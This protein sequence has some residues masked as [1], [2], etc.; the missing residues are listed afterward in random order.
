EIRL[1]GDRDDGKLRTH[2]VQA[3]ADLFGCL[4]GERPNVGILAQV[5][6]PR[7]LYRVPAQGFD[8]V[9]Q[10]DEQKFCRLGE[11]L[12]VFEKP[13]EVELL[14]LRVPIT[15]YTLEAAGAIVEPVR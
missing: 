9:G 3:H 14:F 11:A 1:M 5:V 2:V 7:Q 12:V 4:K 6:A 10:F 8:T 13:E 15:A